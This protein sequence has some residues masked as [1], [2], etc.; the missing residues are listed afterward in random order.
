MLSTTDRLM[1]MGYTFTELSVERLATEA[2]ISRAK[3]YAYFE[4]KSHLL[5]LLARHA[6][7]ELSE[8]AS[9][10]WSTAARKEPADL[11]NAM[12]AIIAAYEAHRALIAAVIEMAEYDTEVNEA[13]QSIMESIVDSVE[14]L[15]VEGESAGWIRSPLASRDT[16]SALTW[17]VERTVHQALRS[18]P[19]Q[20]LDEV[21]D[22]MTEI[23][24][25]TLY[26]ESAGS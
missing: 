6:F 3:F 25:R 24:W 14:T 13:Y 1:G 18:S 23:V 12:R 4:D 10:W 21:A 17:M 22:C 26:L 9:Q 19:A 8:A 5:R 2:G 15:I 7:A 20:D 11:R 16:A